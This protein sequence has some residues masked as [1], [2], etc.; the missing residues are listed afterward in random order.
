MLP[1]AVIFKLPSARAN[2]STSKIDEIIEK[3][4]GEYEQCFW[5]Y[6]DIKEGVSHGK[7]SKL[8]GDEH[9]WVSEKLSLAGISLLPG[10]SPDL[11]EGGNK[12]KY[13]DGFGDRVVDQIKRDK[14]LHNELVAYMKHP[15]WQLAF[16]DVI[17]SLCLIF[18]SSYPMDA[19]A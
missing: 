19:D 15:R 3:Q 18:S 17:K 13:L 7:V 1:P 6:F 5:N 8:C 11:G 10:D 9:K 2:A 16:L 4:N 12:Y 14:S